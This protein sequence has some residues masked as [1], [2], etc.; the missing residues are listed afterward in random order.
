MQFNFS[1]F[2]LILIIT[3]HHTFSDE[4]PIQHSITFPKN[5]PLKIEQYWIS[6]K[7]DGVRGYWDG[8]QLF[9]RQGNKIIAPEW[10]TKGWPNQPLDGELWN[11]RDNFQEI[12]SCVRRKSPDQ[13]CWRTLKFNLFDLPTENSS[14]FDQRINTM[15]TL[16]VKS[17]SSYLSMIPQFKVESIEQ[18][19]I[20]LKLI[21]D[22][23]GEGLML[24][25]QDAVYKQGRNNQL[26]KL[27]TYQDAEA[28]IIKHFEGKGKFTDMLGALLVETPSGLTFKIGSGFSDSQRKDPP[29]V[30][31]I[32]TF[33]YYGKT[34]R[35]VPRFAS[36]LRVKQ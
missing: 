21:V 34:K 1:F 31:S 3:S 28:T 23:G 29:P 14:T 13:T 12:V 19:H 33:K 18:L 7:L 26:L 15:E 11:K 4:L 16:I 27:K 32:I 22:A 20:K 10:F 5:E 35:G 8:E 36:F 9:T 17:A 25:H 6:E 24:H 30:G 2:V